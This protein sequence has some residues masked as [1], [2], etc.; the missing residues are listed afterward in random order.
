MIY[1]FQGIGAICKLPCTACQACCTGCDSCGRAIGGACAECCDAWRRFWEPIQNNPL[2]TYVLFTWVAMA[3]AMGSAGW[4]LSKL[5]E[6]DDDTKGKLALFCI[7]DLVLAAIHSAMAYYMQ[8]RI[9][10]GLGGKEYSQMTAK[11]IQAETGR[12]LLY[13]VPVCL[14]FFVASAAF[15]LNVWGLTVGWGSCGGSQPH[16]GAAFLMLMWGMCAGAYLMCW[17][18]CQC[19]Q[20]A[21]S[22]VKRPAKGAA[23][24]QPPT[25][26]GVPAA[27]A[28]PPETV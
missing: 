24:D 15:A 5:G 11:E 28:P 3:C 14:Y 21:A 9:V 27:T 17:Y 22:S 6:C 19:C 4:G 10:S 20:G 16:W 25:V 18:C 13:D 7:A 8:R 26:V 23:A 2:G 1:I 12:I